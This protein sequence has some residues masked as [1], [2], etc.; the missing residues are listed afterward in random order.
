MPPPNR[1]ARPLTNS[2]AY[3]VPVPLE[4]GMMRPAPAA[5][6]PRRELENLSIGMGRGAVTGMEGTKQL[7]TQPV[8]TAQALI[9]AAR[10]LGTDPA[11]I[12]DMLRA[13]RQRAMSGSLGL[14]ELIGENVTPGMRGRQV[15][16]MRELDVYHGT[17]H[18]FPATEANPLGEFDA[19]K[20]GTGEG[21][22]AYGHGIYLAESPEVARGYQEKLTPAAGWA[23]DNVS[24]GALD[25][26][27][28]VAVTQL[29]MEMNNLGTRNGW[30]DIETARRMAE[31]KLRKTGEPEAAELIAKID[32]EKIKEHSGAFYTADLPDEMIDRML[33]WDKPLSEQPA[34][35]REHVMR[36]MNVKEGGLPADMS[37]INSGGGKYVVVQ[38][39]P[40]L[41]GATF[42]IPRTI[43]KGPRADSPEAAVKAYWN[44]L[45]GEDFYKTLSGD[46]GEGAS[47][48]EHLRALGI[49]GIKYLDA[50]SRGQGGSGTRN[51]VVFPGEEK[52]VRILE[53]K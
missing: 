32:P 19:S 34:A 20:I 17:P 50:G 31:M 51:F 21:A 4:P 44:N 8:A 15:P 43:A 24:A 2:L 23:Y 37:V 5:F 12:L 53:R 33:D 42:G 52:K 16:A 9:E 39:K 28:R 6:N 14:G 26:K 35:V 18:R 41:P 7:L 10:Q 3:S 1:L 22:Q 47:A 40:P 36:Y 29:S 13:A 48:S 45:K 49:P 25:K 30:P 38:E 46:V 11:V 27:T